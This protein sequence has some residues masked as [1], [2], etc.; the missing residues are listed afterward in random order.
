[1]GFSKKI[2]TKQEQPLEEMTPE[3]ATQIIQ[4]YSRVLLNNCPQ[5]DGVAD[6]SELP[7][8]KN[9]IK[10]ALI[11]GLKATDDPNI[12]KA[13]TIGFMKLACWQIGVGAPKAGINLAGLDENTNLKK[14]VQL[15][16]EQEARNEKWRHLVQVEQNELKE[17]LIY[18]GFWV[19]NSCLSN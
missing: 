8:P 10:Q 9:Q 2:C 11:I 19:E 7:Y 15:L 1:M 14:L 17:D 13:L 3:L 6:T 5:P 18:L 12:Q 4:E 16:L